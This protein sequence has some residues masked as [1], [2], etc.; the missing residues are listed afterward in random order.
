[1]SVT[2]WNCAAREPFG[3]G[4]QSWG[5][6]CGR[7]RKS[8]RDLVRAQSPPS[9]V[10][11]AFTLLRAR[12][13]DRGSRWLIQLPVGGFAT[14]ATKTEAQLVAGYF[15]LAGGAAAPLAFSSRKAVVQDRGVFQLMVISLVDQESMW[16]MKHFWGLQPAS[17]VC[18]TGSWMLELGPP[19]RT[20]GG[21]FGN[22]LLFWKAQKRWC[23][24][25]R[26]R[27]P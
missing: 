8:N 15:F 27:S 14:P 1:M 24:F 17:L 19:E 12:K 5:G 4:P 9:E 6:V 22:T 23:G 13:T 11:R 20:P 10:L 2:G 18:A 26:A 21:G 7:P 3:V 25:C 16:S